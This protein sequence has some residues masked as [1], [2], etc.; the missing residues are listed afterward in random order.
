MKLLIFLC[1]FIPVAGF[2]QS[3]VLILQKHGKNIRSYIPGDP[4][5][6][7]TVYDQWFD[8]TLTSLHHDSVSVDGIAFHWKEIK[9]IRWRRTGLNYTADG[10]ILMIAGAGWLAINAINGIYRKDAI[11]DWYT[12]SGVVIGA[13]LIGGGFLLRKAAV[14]TYQLGHKYDL[15][16]LELTD[17]RKSLKSSQPVNQP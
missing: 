1:L 6:M 16:Y 14:K 2:G 15:H 10:T 11:G 13:A 12:T 4:I 9:A 7:Q 17:L 5:I 3:D 8:G